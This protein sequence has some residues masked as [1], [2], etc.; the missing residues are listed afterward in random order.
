V[1]QVLREWGDRW[2]VDTPPLRVTHH[3]HDL[4]VGSV[5]DTCGEPVRGADIERE[6]TVE[7]WDRSGPR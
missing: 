3:G 5:C 2:A 4:R 6:M 7:G 1:L